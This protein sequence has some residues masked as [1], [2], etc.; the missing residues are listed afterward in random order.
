MPKKSPTP[1]FGYTPEQ[2]KEMQDFFG[3]ERNGSRCFKILHE[4]V[5]KVSS[6]I[7]VLWYNIPIHSEEKEKIL[8]VRSKQKR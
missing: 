3:M 2:I 5:Q 6:L 1:D 8:C 4:K 7:F